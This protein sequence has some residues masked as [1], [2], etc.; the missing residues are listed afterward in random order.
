MVQQ[1]LSVSPAS[2]T[3]PN[4]TRRR[5]RD[6]QGRNGSRVVHAT[7]AFAAT[8]ANFA[9]LALLTAVGSRWAE[10][11]GSPLGALRDEAGSG[12]SL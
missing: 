2:V 8:G 1:E 11:S 5:D 9:F 7:D 10:M 6:P 3:S 12:R 4:G